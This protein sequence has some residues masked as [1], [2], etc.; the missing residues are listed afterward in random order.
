M[1]E[2]GS[3]LQAICEGERP[4]DVESETLEFKQEA[5]TAKDT[6]RRIAQAAVCFANASGGKIVVGLDDKRSGKDAFIGSSLDPALLRARI[7]E[8]TQ[9]GLVTSCEEYAFEGVRLVLVDVPEGIEIYSDRQGAVRRRVGKQ[10]LPMS[11]QDQLLTRERRGVGDVTTAVSQRTVCD[12]RPEAMATAREFLKQRDDLWSELGRASDMDLLRALGVLSPEGKLLRAGELLLCDPLQ[13]ATIVLYQHRPTPGGEATLVQRLSGPLILV[14]GQV[15]ELAWSRRNVTPVNLPAG[16]QIDVS[17]FPQPAVREVI[18]NALLHRMYQLPGPVNVEH[19][20]SSFVVESPGPLVAGVDEANIL[21]HP[22]KPR[23]RCLFDAARMLSLA[24]ATGRG[25]D[26][27]YREM[28]LAGH[29]PPEISQRN[30][31]TRV[32]FTSG[33]PRTQVVAFLRSL[34]ELERV[35][36]DTLLLVVTMLRSRTIT[37]EKLAT[38]IQ[39]SEIEAREVLN[40]HAQ[41]H[42]AILEIT[43]ETERMR[44]HTY[45]LSPSALQALGN[46]VEYH[47]APARHIEHKVIAHVR[48]YGRI[49][50]RTVRNLLDVDVQ[51]A[52]VLLRNL[53]KKRLLIRTSEQKRGPSVEYGPGPDFPN[54]LP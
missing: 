45:R 41:G 5:D 43:R 10:C 35:D 29:H 32:V 18:A 24:E 38:R 30:D 1:S 13:S 34:P 36:I 4:S 39:K 21:T 20:P 54:S 27:M 53:R 44:T 46:A 31:A 51:M 15:V 2:I 52:S 40:R 12:I 47:R 11:A 26:R 7:Y 25:V 37:A 8:L 14:F 28:I 22:S 42:N 33:T 9:P 17:D 49:T 48:E 16:T 50:N 23:N 6:H 19:S 3:V